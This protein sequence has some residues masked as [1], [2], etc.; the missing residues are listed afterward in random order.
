[1]LG[2]GPWCSARMVKGVPA[3]KAK[4]KAVDSQFMVDSGTEK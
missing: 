1:M 4:R 3:R 2:L